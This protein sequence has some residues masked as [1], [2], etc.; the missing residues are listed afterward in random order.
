[1]RVTGHPERPP[2]ARGQFPR[3][4]VPQLHATHADDL[5]DKADLLPFQVFAPEVL[6]VQIS[7]SHLGAPSLNAGSVETDSQGCTEAHSLTTAS[8]L[9]SCLSPCQKGPG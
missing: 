4:V 3:V 5:A 9:M 7:I 1:M 2:Q 8:I 6:G